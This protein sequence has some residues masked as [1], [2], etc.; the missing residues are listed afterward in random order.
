[1]HEVHAT[2]T[3]NNHQSTFHLRS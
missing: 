2:I 3:Y 1:M